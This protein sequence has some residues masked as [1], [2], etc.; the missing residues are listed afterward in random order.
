MATNSRIY[1]QIADTGGKWT[2]ASAGCGS[3][4][5]FRL[6]PGRSFITSWK[7]R[8]KFP[9][10]Q[11]LWLHPANRGLDLSLD[12]LRVR[13]WT[14]NR[15]KKSIRNNRSL[16]LANGPAVAGRSLPESRDRSTCRSAGQ[17]T[18]ASFPLSGV[19]AG[20]IFQRPAASGRHR[21]DAFLQTTATM[22]LGRLVS[23]GSGRATIATAFSDQ[24]L[25]AQIDLR[26]NW[27]FTRPPPPPLP[28]PSHWRRRRIVIDDTT[29]H[30]KLG[31]TSDNWLGWLPVGGCRRRGRPSRSATKSRGWCRR[32]RRYQAI[33]RCFT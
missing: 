7:V 26:A 30:G 10:I 20:G 32:M 29:L 11:A 2:C 22:I 19:D 5:M 21:D 12:L 16:K 14:E 9:P 31:V 17:P 13:A 1:P 15:R 6:Q 25:S 28:H 8:E 3:A 4:P 27:P 33:P 18:A 23:I 24:P